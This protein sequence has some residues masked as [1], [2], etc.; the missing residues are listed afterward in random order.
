MASSLIYIYGR[1]Q[2]VVAVHSTAVSI[3]R[4]LVAIIKFARGSA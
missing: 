4:S 2:F 1:G 3:V